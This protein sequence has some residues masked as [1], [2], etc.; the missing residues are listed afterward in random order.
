MMLGF[1]AANPKSMSCSTA[2]R[3]SV[4]QVSKPY[5]KV[6]WSLIKVAHTQTLIP[7]TGTWFSTS[8]GVSQLVALPLVGGVVLRHQC[9]G[10]LE[11]GDCGSWLLVY[12][13]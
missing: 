5:Q 6:A 8:S 1:P 2:V 9:H 3:L 11:K 7:R 10:D 12:V 13:A 4:I